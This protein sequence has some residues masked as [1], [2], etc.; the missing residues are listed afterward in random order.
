VDQAAISDLVDGLNQS[1]S[2]LVVIE[3]PTGES[4]LLVGGGLGRF[5]VTYV[6]SD[7]R[8]AVAVDL[9]AEPDVEIR[10]VAGGQPGNF[11]ARWVVSRT[12]AIQAATTFS[13]T[14]SLTAELMWEWT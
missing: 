5:I 12:T 3:P 1:T 11:P 6:E 14:G 4:V 2:S 10:V 7:Q 13:Q 8:S 9:S